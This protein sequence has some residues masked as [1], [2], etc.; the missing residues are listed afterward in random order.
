M[1]KKHKLPEQPKQ[2]I[3]SVLL[4]GNFLTQAIFINED[5]QLT[6]SVQKKYA[7]LFNVSLDRVMIL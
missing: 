3:K 4:D 2:M 5:G 1:P 6:N 7:E